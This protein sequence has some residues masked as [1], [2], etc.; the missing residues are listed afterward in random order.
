MNNRN[1]VCNFTLSCGN[2]GI[3]GQT[4]PNIYAAFWGVQL[5]IKIG[6]IIDDVIESDNIKSEDIIK[7]FKNY[8]EEKCQFF[9][10]LLEIVPKIIEK[11]HVH[12]EFTEEMVA[13]IA[14]ENM[15]NNIPNFYICDHSH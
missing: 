11:L 12:E 10:A 1:I 5:E 14:I 6:E 9:P 7:K 15:H 8:L 13:Q 3:D 2:F 4:D